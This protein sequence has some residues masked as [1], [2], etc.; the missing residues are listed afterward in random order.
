M[1]GVGQILEVGVGAWCRSD[2]GGGARCR[3]D[4]RGRG[5]CMV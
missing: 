2:I 3:S 5:R 1:H 4:I